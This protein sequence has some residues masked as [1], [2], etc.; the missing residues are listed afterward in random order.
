[1]TE[2]FLY[3]IWQYKTY[4]GELLTTEG[5]E[6]TIVNPGILNLD[7]GPDFSAAKLIIGNTEWNGSI[8]MHVKSSDWKKHNHNSNAAYDSVILH[9]V[10]QHDM[11]ITTK[12]GNKLE[13]LELKGKFKISP[14]SKYKDLQAG[15]SWIPCA[16]Q[17]KTIDK[18]KLHSW[19]DRLLIERLER[20]T[21]QIEQSLAN[22]NNNWEQS[23]YIA[24]ARNFGFNT[25]ADPFEQLAKST[26][27]D[28][29]AK[30]KDDIFQIEAILCGQSSLINPIISDEY[31]TKLNNEYLFLKKKHELESVYSYQWKFMRMRPVNFPTIRIAQFASL[32]HN[33]SHLFSKIIKTEK[34]A[35]L[36]NHFDINVSEYWQNHY[37]F[38]KN[39]K[40]SKKNFGSTSFDLI[41][42]NTIIPF[43]FVYANH[44][45]NEELKNRALNYLHQTKSETNSIIKR[46]AQDGVKAE[47][48]A[49][50]Q[51]LIQL[52]NNYCSY[53]KCLQCRIGIEL[54][55]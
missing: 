21:E 55:C 14:Y 1:M 17:I 46:F 37:V 52:K 9:V 12:G 53:T 25:N 4:Q 44:H 13:V 41:L 19:F 6:I 18:F 39:A 54:I 3:F 33:S 38:G 49:H 2:D 32:V 29:L 34:L 43:L 40:N 7:S 36:R 23:F 5:K 22:T 8:E 45:G 20:K 26:P 35:D 31:S 10:Y 15:L 47:N 30:Y 48:A 11:E 24:L 27:L 42:I 16:S 28:L 50:S 51:A